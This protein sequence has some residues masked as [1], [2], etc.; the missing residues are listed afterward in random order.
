MQD[1]ENE[2]HLNKSD[3]PRSRPYLNLRKRS[4]P[5]CLWSTYQVQSAQWHTLQR[6]HPNA[7]AINGHFMGNCIHMYGRSLV[8][9]EHILLAYCTR[10]FDCLQLPITL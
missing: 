2:A 1:N 9:E 3:A 5:A 7:F 10:L 6:F 4:L 8:V